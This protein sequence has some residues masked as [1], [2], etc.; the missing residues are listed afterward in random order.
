M[1]MVEAVA[2]STQAG[3]LLS[4]SVRFRHVP[5]AARISA[6][7]AGTRSDH[8][9]DE[10]SGTISIEMRAAFRGNQKMGTGAMWISTMLP[11]A[12]PWMT[13]LAAG[14]SSPRS[15]V[16]IESTGTLGMT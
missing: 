2:E 6:T 1:S 3:A 8:G 11:G 16:R 9:D 5:K 15:F 4:H 10:Y 14:T 12:T 7:P 13:C